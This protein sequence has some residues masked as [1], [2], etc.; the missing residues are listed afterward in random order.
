MEKKYDEKMNWKNIENAPKDG[1]LILVCNEKYY[2][3]TTAS[4]KTYHPNAKGK[5]TWRNDSGIKIDPTHWMELP[6]APYSRF[7]KQL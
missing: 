1:T 7:V 5:I 4:W 2:Y 6:S 3:P